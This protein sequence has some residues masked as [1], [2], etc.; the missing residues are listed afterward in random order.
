MIFCTIVT[1]NAARNPSFRTE[2]ADGFALPISSEESLGS[3][4]KESLFDFM[5]STHTATND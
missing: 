5:H 2:R 1:P 3:W 4:R